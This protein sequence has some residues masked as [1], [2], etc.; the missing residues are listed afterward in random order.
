[1]KKTHIMRFF[2]ADGGGNPTGGTP[3]GAGDPPS[4]IAAP[5]SGTTPPV[6]S[7]DVPWIGADGAFSEKWT[8]KLPDDLKEAAP[9]LGKYKTVTDLAKA[10]HNAN[11]L[12]GKKTL[13]PNEK[14]TPEEISVY[15]KAL[16]IPDD[17]K[18]YNI[19]P[20]ELPEGLSWNDENG[21]RFM[22]LGYKYNIP[23][24][25][26]KAIVA[27]YGAHRLAEM[28]VMAQEIDSRKT[29][30][31]EDLKKTWGENFDKNL[32]VAQQAAKLAGV[33]PESFGF[34]DPEVVKGFVRLAAQLSD[35]KLVRGAGGDMT[36]GGAARAKDIQ[37][38]PQNPLHAKYKDGDPD[39]VQMVRNYLQ[40]G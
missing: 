16:G 32:T 7:G 3:G 11:A 30:G 4:L 22:E 18:E 39:T 13:V 29:A 31:V 6:A 26:M 21:K 34:G 33:N 8:E 24:A 38:N 10:L 25:A 20:D 5:A 27:E 28:Q 14:S 37:T 23:P 19:K 12:I 15:R 36:Q 9:T 35:D 17:I 40:Q 2:E 1:M